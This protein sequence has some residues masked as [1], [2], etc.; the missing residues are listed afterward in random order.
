M[1]L[2]QCLL[3]QVIQPNFMRRLLSDNIRSLY[4]V[5]LPKRGFQEGR[6]YLGIFMICIL[7]PA[8]I[9]FLKNDQEEF[10]S[11]YVD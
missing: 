1:G 6:S 5:V 7:L 9:E 11:F 4:V 10:G 8:F 3:H 2:P